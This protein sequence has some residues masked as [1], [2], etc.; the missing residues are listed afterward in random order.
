MSGDELYSL[1]FSNTLPPPESLQQP[2]KGTAKARGFSVKVSLGRES[3]IRPDM[4]EAT[5]WET[6]PAIWEGSPNPMQ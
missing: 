2:Q 6:D 3:I 1:A 4:T 5:Y